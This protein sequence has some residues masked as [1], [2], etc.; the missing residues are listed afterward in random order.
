MSRF[1]NRL[2]LLTWLVVINI[3]LTLILLWRT[4]AQ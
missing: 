3:V 4:L 2:T 1:D